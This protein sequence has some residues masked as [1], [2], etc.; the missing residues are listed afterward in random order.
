MTSDE[1]VESCKSRYEHA[2][3]Q[4]VRNPDEIRMFRRN[5][6][7]A[8]RDSGDPV[9]SVVD[10]VNKGLKKCANQHWV[11][12]D[13]WAHCGDCDAKKSPSALA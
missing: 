6:W 5:Y 7:R 12:A 13:H 8:M 4:S 9:C 10:C 3:R 11:C 1:R 2:L